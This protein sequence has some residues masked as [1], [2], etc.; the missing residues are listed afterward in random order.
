MTRQFQE[1]AY[2]RLT[3]ER[4]NWKKKPYNIN[5]KFFIPPQKT[6]TMSCQFKISH[7]Q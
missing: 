7:N 4:M 5:V 1:V 6:H 2:Q 3:S